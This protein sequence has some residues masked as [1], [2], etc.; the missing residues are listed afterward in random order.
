[1]SERPRALHIAPIMPA[2]SGNGLAMRQGMFLE[3]LSRSFETRLIVLPVVGRHDAPAAL[4]EEL[5]VATTVIPVA[6][7]Q[8]T[9][10]TLLARLADP[11]ARLSAFRS[12]GRSSFAS[13][14]SSLVLAELRAA[15]GAERYDLVHLG[16]SYL[17]DTLE[18][19]DAARATVD[20]DEDE[21][22][23]YREIA[24][25]LEPSDPVGS[26][27]AAAEADAMAALIGRQAP[28]FAVRF[29]SSRLD[30]ALIEERHPTAGLEVIENAVSVP[31]APHRRDDGATLLFLGS[32][33][34]APNVDA[35]NWLVEEIWP[36]VQRRT[37]RPLRL[38][39]VGRDAGRLARLGQRDGV[40]VQPDIEDVAEAYGRATVFLAPLRAGAGTRLK[41]LEAAAHRVPVVTTTL[42]ARGLPFESGKHLL[43]ADSVAGFA[44][45][46]LDTIADARA[47]ATRV[48]AAWSIVRS[49]YQRGGVIERLACRLSEIA[50]T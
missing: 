33:G 12:Y 18:V 35:A 36:L 22:T 27:W 48:E 7:R 15:A 30:A 9:H 44:E 46:T 1:M 45:A 16:R 14:L 20:L 26:A 40:E 6:G 41:L 50:A 42:G 34:Y 29:I 28:I 49:H 32:F 11:A 19:L 10:F 8:D 38:L 25:T 23:S 13:H 5:G 4:P 3:A 47:S 17:G 24:A 39:I 31:L 21:W 37:A 43:L 2:R